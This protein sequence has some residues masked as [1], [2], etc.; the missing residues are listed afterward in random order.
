[1]QHQLSLL[2]TLFSQSFGAR[3]RKNRFNLLWTFV[4]PIGQMTVLMLIFSLIGRTAAYGRSFALFLIAGLT[5]LAVFTQSAQMVR[6]AVLQLSRQSRLAEIGLFHEAVVRTIFVVIVNAISMSAVLYGISI[7]QRVETMPQH[8][9]HVVS[10]FF[11][12]MVMGFGIGLLRAY[13]VLFFSIADKVYTIISRGLIFVSGVFYMPSYMPP[14]FR[15]ALSWNP[16]LHGVELLRL[17]IYREY[18]TTV[19]DPLYLK[20]VA[21]GATVAGMALLWNRRALVMG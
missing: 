3:D 7:V 13:W 12:T 2:W 15:E 14:V 11:W 1:M 17:G 10:A 5:I 8:W 9:H 20:T 19:L 6:G 16:V 18:P 21:L 4:E